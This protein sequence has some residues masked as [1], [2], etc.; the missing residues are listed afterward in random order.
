MTIETRIP[1]LFEVGTQVTD[2]DGVIKT[3]WEDGRGLDFQQPARNP[4]PNRYLMVFKEAAFK[5]EHL[6]L[7]MESDSRLKA[8]LERE[9]E[10]LPSARRG[11]RSHDEVTPKSGEEEKAQ[12][13]KKAAKEGKQDSNKSSAPKPSTEGSKPAAKKFKISEETTVPKKADGTDKKEKE[14]TPAKKT[15]TKT[16]A[17][18][19]EVDA[20]AKPEESKTTPKTTPKKKTPETAATPTS[21][22]KTGSTTTTPKSAKKVKA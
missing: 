22:K 15:E 12:P 10:H 5:A 14:D 20:P 16:E 4:H 13:E 11:K 17:A 19:M 21:T 18:A 6:Q 2:A 9:N 7:L 8:L 1:T 3:D